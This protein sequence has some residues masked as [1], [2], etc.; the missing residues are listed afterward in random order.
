MALGRPPRAPGADHFDIAPDARIDPRLL[1]RRIATVAGVVA[2]GFAIVAGQLVRLGLKEPSDVRISAAEQISPVASRPDIVDRRGRLLATDVANPSLYADPSVV[3]DADE[4]VEKLRTVLPNLDEAEVRRLLSD[5]SRRFAWLRRGISPQTAQ[6][7][8]DLGLPG[9]HFRSEPKRIYPAGMLAG[10][11]LGNVNADNRGMSGVERHIDAGRESA[12][13]AA[14][15]RAA[16]RISIDS[17]VQHALQT[18]LAYAIERYSASGAAGLVLDVDTGEVLAATSLPE[19][20]PN[21]PAEA[22]RLGR[23]D[24]LM[25]G[26]FE[27]GSIWKML[28]V[29]LALDAGTA[30]LATEVDVRDPIKIGNHTI[31]DLHPQKR[32]LSVRD[33][34][35][36]SS[37]VGAGLLALE[38]GGEGQRAFLERLGLTGAM[39][40]EAGPLAAPLLPQTWGKAETVTIAYGH[41]LAVAPLQFAAAAASLVNGGY[42]VTPSFLARDPAT[43]APARKKVLAT[44]TSD[45]IREIMRLNVT[46]PYGTGRRADVEGYRLGGKTGTAE[47]PGIGGYL[48]KSVIASFLAVLPTDQPKY[49]TLVMLFEP[50]GEATGG[51]I[52]AGVNAAPVTAKVVAR[53]APVLGLLPRRIEGRGGIPK[54]WFDAVVEQ[55]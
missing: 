53:I 27:L 42:Q 16:V 1:N 36:H 55:N 20:D 48:R 3:L 9:L 18:E 30:T 41:G 4:A 32:K 43:P 26:V 17:G 13:A 47:M 28:T 24:K 15:D 14:G 45:A 25:Q 8:H 19:V 44:S 22:L 38:I 39:R 23:L 35:V 12:G 2:L 11:V 29:A 6:A 37:N 52:T 51:Q 34:F 31:T 5:R 50:N 21:Q 10:H 49:L 54:E 40:T 46:L 33:V 7:V